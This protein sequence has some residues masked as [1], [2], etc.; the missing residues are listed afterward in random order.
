MLVPPNLILESENPIIHLME[1]QKSVTSK[2]GTMRLGAYPCK[3]RK[4]LSPS[5][6]YGR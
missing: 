4:A 3:L 2:G 5:L 6:A 1:E